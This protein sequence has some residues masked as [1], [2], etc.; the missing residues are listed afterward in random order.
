M[1]TWSLTLGEDLG[2]VVY[3]DRLP[4]GMCQSNKDRK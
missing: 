1:V 3:G 2:L 4:K